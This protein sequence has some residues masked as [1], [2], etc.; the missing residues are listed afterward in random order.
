MKHE[1]IATSGQPVAVRSHF[2]QARL[3]TQRGD[4]LG[5]TQD[6]GFCTVPLVDVVVLPNQDLPVLSPQLNQARVASIGRN[7]FKVSAYR[8]FHLWSH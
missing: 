1:A 3:L 4:I 2:M 8:V 5:M 7:A 6:V